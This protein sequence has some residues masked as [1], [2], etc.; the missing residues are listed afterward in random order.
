MTS[1]VML[2][3]NSTPANVKASQ[4]S[5]PP[6]DAL[7]ALMEGET[8]DE[9]ALR[10]ADERQEDSYDTPLMKNSARK[11]PKSKPRFEQYDGDHTFDHKPNRSQGDYE[12]RPQD[13][14]TLNSKDSFLADVSFSSKLVMYPWKAG[15]ICLDYIVK[16]ACLKFEVA[17]LCYTCRE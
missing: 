17:N 11:Q 2:K 10:F 8:P 5:A 6:K 3:R 15:C 16:S 9:K 1:R 14:S 4:Q 12:Y 13:T 7:A